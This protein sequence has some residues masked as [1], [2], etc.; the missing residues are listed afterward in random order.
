MTDQGPTVFLRAIARLALVGAALGLVVLWV[1]SL[2]QCSRERGPSETP[3]APELGPE[4]INFVRNRILEHRERYLTYLARKNGI[5]EGLPS[6]EIDRF[7]VGRE[8]M[9]GTPTL[10][11]ESEDFIWRRGQLNQAVST[12]IED[13]GL[14][15][16]AESDP[17][18]RASEAC[19]AWAQVE[20]PS[21]MRKKQ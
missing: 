17:T 18:V 14:P 10:L 7:L 3:R 13:L 15:S 11:L 1:R 16:P 12:V 4:Q 9:L 5:Q 19:R 8:P 2:R 6:A 20:S 21:L